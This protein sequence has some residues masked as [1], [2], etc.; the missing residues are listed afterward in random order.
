MSQREGHEVRTD[1]YEKAKNYYTQNG[2]DNSIH[3]DLVERF[4]ND[5]RLQPGHPNYLHSG[6]DRMLVEGQHGDAHRYQ[7]EV[8][9]P[10]QRENRLQ[11]A[12]KTVVKGK[13]ETDPRLNPESEHYAHSGVD[14]FMIESWHKS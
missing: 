6:I 10:A 14:R 11:D 7:K 9:E 8:A 12:L 3:P 13:T 1:L 4:A 5:T 2:T